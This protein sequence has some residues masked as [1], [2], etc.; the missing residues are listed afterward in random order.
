MHFFEL[1]LKVMTDFKLNYHPNQLVRKLPSNIR[2]LFQFLLSLSI[3][4]SKAGSFLELD[5]DQVRSSSEPTTTTIPS[6]RPPPC[7]PRSGS[8]RIGEVRSRS[9]LGNWRSTCSEVGLGLR[10]SGKRFRLRSFPVKLQYSMKKCFYW[11]P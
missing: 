10:N 2:Q 7:W 8:D 11:K 1:K 3:V 9:G 6:G 5:P 4:R